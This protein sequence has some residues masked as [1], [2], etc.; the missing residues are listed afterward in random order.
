MLI[1]FSILRYPELLGKITFTPLYN[2]VIKK[3]ATEEEYKKFSSE[4]YK[5][6]AQC[7]FLQQ[8]I[9]DFS[10]KKYIKNNIIYHIP[11]D[12]LKYLYYT[13]N[14]LL[15]KKNIPKQLYKKE[16]NCKRYIEIELNY[17]NLIENYSI[18]SSHWIVCSDKISLKTIFI[19]PSNKDEVSVNSTYKDIENNWYIK[20]YNENYKKELILLKNGYKK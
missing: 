11:G 15:I 13:K 10:N 1:D 4:K 6:E 20:H 19:I 2:T 12:I 18:F 7:K 17:F 16:L 14:K 3:T 5:T 8:H 9:L